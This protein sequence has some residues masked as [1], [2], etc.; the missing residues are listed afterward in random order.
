M[1]RTSI[2]DLP[3]ARKQ[4]RHHDGRPVNGIIRPQM[5]VHCAGCDEACLGLGSTIRGAETHLSKQGWGKAHEPWSHTVWVW[6][7]PQCVVKTREYFE[8]H[9]SS[10]GPTHAK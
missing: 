5:E 9:E 2:L 10:D 6:I 4:Y 7:C 3:L 8:H 1:K